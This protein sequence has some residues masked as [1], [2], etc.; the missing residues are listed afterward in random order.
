MIQ[1][2]EVNLADGEITFSSQDIANLLASQDQVVLLAVT[3]GPQ[4]EERVTKLFANDQLTKATILDAIGSVAVE[5]AA[6]QLN[7]KIAKKAE[8]IGLPSLTMRYSPG[9]G[10]LDLENQPQLLDL[11]QGQELGIKTNDSFLLIPQKSITALI[12][13]GREKSDVQAKC[14]FDC[15]NC[16]YDTCVYK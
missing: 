1:E 3:I 9:Y 12:G 4:L 8:K 11:V 7:Q 10:D 6:N 2:K 16:A 13:L 5:E 15:H 14:D